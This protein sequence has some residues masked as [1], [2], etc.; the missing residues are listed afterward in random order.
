MST[1]ESIALLTDSGTNVPE[2]L[3]EKYGIYCAYLMVNYHDHQYREV[4]EISAAEVQAHFDE[5]IPHTSTPSPQD[6]SAIFEQA[7]ADGHD[8]LLCVL[9]SSGLTSTFMVFESIAA[10]H[11]E[12]TIEADRHQEHRCGRGHHRAVRLRA[13]A[14]RNGLGPAG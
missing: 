2:A 5:E 13:D 9:T 7:I 10:T 3:L 1:A 14:C 11:P 4:K 12:V 8:H 6:V